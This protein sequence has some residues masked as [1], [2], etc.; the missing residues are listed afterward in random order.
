MTCLEGLLWRLDHR[1]TVCCS[2]YA[3]GLRQVVECLR[4]ALGCIPSC[5]VIRK[6]QAHLVFISKEEDYII[7]V[8]STV[9]C[10]F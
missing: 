4:I 5:E 10:R 1:E 8:A 6:K 2:E 9:H 7:F 3:V